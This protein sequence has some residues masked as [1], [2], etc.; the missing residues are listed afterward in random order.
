MQYKLQCKLSASLVC[1]LWA[2]IIVMQSIWSD[3]K[4]EDSSMTQCKFNF[5]NKDYDVSKM[6]LC[7]LFLLVLYNFA[8][9]QAFS[10]TKWIFF[11]WITIIDWYTTLFKHSFLKARNKI[12]SLFSICFSSHRNY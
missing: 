12:V 11:Y 6:L 4:I 2:K 3:L 7:P 5:T 10:Q 8:H 1:T 9:F